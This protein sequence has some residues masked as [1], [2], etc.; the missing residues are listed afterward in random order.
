MN[1]RTVGQFALETDRIIVV[2]PMT[3]TSVKLA[4]SA[5]WIT[6]ANEVSPCLLFTKELML[7]VGYLVLGVHAALDRKYLH[8]RNYA[9]LKMNVTRQV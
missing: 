6:L 1:A 3:R 4:S 7:T 2:K 8:H 9:V 5:H